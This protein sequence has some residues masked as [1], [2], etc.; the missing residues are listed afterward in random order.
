MS[1]LKTNFVQI[2]KSTTVDDNFTLYRPDVLDG[3][4]R[5]G[6]GI[7]GDV[8]D[9]LTVGA[10]GVKANSF[11]DGSNRKLLIKDETGTIVWGE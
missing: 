5:L 6:Q 9:V 4:V 7:A 8:T 1:L 2:G 10:D 11:Y 3:T